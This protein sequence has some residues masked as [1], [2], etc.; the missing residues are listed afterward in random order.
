MLD[1]RRPPYSRLPSHLGLIPDG[2]RRWAE[3]RGLPKSARY[4]AGIAPGLEVLALCRSLGIREVSAYGFTENTHRPRD[5]WW[6]RDAC[7]A[8][9]WPTAGVGAV[10]GDADAD[11]FPDALRPFVGLASQGLR[12]STC[13]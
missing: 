5:R 4:K 12:D 6:V 2:N 11:M 8:L 9:R 1:V 3:Q 13:W 10:V 7:T